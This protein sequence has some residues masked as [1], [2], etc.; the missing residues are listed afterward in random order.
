MQSLRDACDSEL[1]RAKIAASE[2]ADRIQ[3]NLNAY[4]DIAAGHEFLFRDLDALVLKDS[5][6]FS[7][8][9]N[10]RIDNHVK[11]EAERLEAERAKIRAQEEARAAAKLA[12][13][14]LTDAN[15]TR[16]ADPATHPETPSAKMVSDRANDAIMEE[17]RMLEK[18]RSI[19]GSARLLD[20]LDELAR[21]MT[22]SELSDLCI[23]AAHILSERKAAA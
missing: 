21:R 14:R 20:R 22:E 13:D 6:G 16:Y 9:V 3:I 12:R 19:T 10:Q 23:H 2:Q 4:A 1:A 15:Q 5:D 18:A 7:A 17:H 11:A 8:I